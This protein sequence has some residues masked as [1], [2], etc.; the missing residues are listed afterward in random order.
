MVNPENVSIPCHRGYL[1]W[2]DVGITVN[3]QRHVISSMQALYN[4]G[5]RLAGIDKN[6][7]HGIKIK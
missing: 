2:R 4:V 1:I 3:G 6:G 7:F 5:Q